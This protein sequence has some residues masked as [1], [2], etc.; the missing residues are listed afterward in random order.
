M[1]FSKH[2]LVRIWYDFMTGTEAGEGIARID[3]GKCYLILLGYVIPDTLIFIVHLFPDRKFRSSVQVLNPFFNF[4]VCCKIGSRFILLYVAVQFFQHHLSKRTFSPIV[5]SWPLWCK[6]C[7]SL[8]L[9]SPSCYNKI[10]V[11][12]YASTIL[13]QLCGIVWN[14]RVWYLQLCSFSGLL[15]WECFVVPYKF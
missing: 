5:Y 15:Y 3:L 14:Q 13:L 10:W 12:F 4:C 2:V 8:F 11:C 1:Y 7:I 9:G 6:L